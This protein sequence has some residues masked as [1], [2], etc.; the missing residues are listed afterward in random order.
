M[1]MSSRL[2]KARALRWLGGL[3]AEMATNIRCFGEVEGSIEDRRADF[4]RGA[5]PPTGAT[6][7]V[8]LNS[9]RLG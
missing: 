4:V 7:F 6:D 5:R 8:G 1:I 2:T 3:A 9:W